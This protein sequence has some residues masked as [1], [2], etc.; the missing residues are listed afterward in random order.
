MPEKCS[1]LKKSYI[2]LFDESKYCTCC[3]RYVQ[4]VY[5]VHSLEDVQGSISI[6]EVF[7][8]MPFLT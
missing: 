8:Q 3:E 1:I 4:C 7:A 2:D 6:I 5:I